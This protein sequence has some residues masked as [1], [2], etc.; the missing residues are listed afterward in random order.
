MLTSASTVIGA[1]NA[2]A[3]FLSGERFGAQIARQINLVDE[4]TSAENLRERGEEIISGFLKAAPEA[5]RH[6]KDLIRE[7]EQLKTDG[8][9]SVS[10]YTTELIAKLRISEEGQEGMAALLEKRKPNWLE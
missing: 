1:A 3:W 4:I 6:A 8:K 7:V 5:Q 2:R 9:E 10:K